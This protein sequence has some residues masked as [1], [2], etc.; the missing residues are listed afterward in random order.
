M[1]WMP[2]PRIVETP[3]AATAAHTLSTERTSYK[4]EFMPKSFDIRILTA[5]GVTGMETRRSREAPTLLISPG[6]LPR[7]E[8]GPGVRVTKRTRI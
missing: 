8:F 7:D 4:R 3:R 1:D 2:E 5:E 6:L